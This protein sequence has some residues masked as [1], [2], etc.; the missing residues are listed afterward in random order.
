MCHHGCSDARPSVVCWVAVGL[1]A[2]LG[3]FLGVPWASLVVS[4][5]GYWAS[6]GGLLASCIGVGYDFCIGVRSRMYVRSY[7]TLC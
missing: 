5:V 2:A 1:L 6:P 4:W 7:T 3:V